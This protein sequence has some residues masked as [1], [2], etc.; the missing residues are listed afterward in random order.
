MEAPGSPSKPST[1]DVWIMPRSNHPAE[2]DHDRGEYNKKDMKASETAE[3]AQYT[4]HRPYARFIY[5]SAVQDTFTHSPT[6]VATP[7]H[8]S[9]RLIVEVSAVDVVSYTPDATPH[10]STGEEEL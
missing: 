10:F 4:V 1:G 7:P 6:V 8:R 5:N 3:C 9:E 2:K